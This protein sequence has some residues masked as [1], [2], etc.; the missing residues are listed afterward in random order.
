MENGGKT[1]A[2]LKFEAEQRKAQEAYIETY[3]LLTTD[4]VRNAQAA[5]QA[6]LEKLRLETEQKTERAKKLKEKAMLISA[7]NVSKQELI[8]SM[9]SRLEDMSK[10]LSRLSM[11]QVQAEAAEERKA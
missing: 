11:A 10:E 7:E 9:S 6:A 3:N 2:Q 5:E 8:D 4:A 1:T